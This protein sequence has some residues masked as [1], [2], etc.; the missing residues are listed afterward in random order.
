MRTSLCRAQHRW[1]ARVLATVPLVIAGHAAALAADPVIGTGERVT[2]EL[3]GLLT[4][5]FMALITALAAWAIKQL[6]DHNVISKQ[7][8]EADMN[9]QVA[10]AASRLAPELIAMAV[11]GGHSLFD[12]TA[13]N[14]NVQR[15]GPQ[16]RSKLPEVADALK[17]SDPGLTYMVLQE[18]KKMLLTQ[19]SQSERLS[20]LPKGSPVKPHAGA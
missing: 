12:L 14:L 19:T 9:R 6:R 15:F 5:V 11:E 10:D 1:M 8:S 7:R 13:R 4:P 18:A 17:V 20:L 3:V 2:D 16:L